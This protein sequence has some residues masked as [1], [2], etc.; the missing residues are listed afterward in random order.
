M[1]Q[2]PLYPGAT[3]CLLSHDYD[4]HN[5]Y[6]IMLLSIST[7][8]GAQ[9]KPLGSKRSTGQSTH[10]SQASHLAQTT[11]IRSEA[12]V[13]SG[14]RAIPVK[15]APPP[16]APP[17]SKAG[18]KYEL[19]QKR[20]GKNREYNPEKFLH[21]QVKKSGEGLTE[22]MRNENRYAGMIK[23]AH[24]DPNS[25]LSKARRVLPGTMEYKHKQAIRQTNKHAGAL[26]DVMHDT[27]VYHLHSGMSE[28]AFNTLNTKAHAALKQRYAIHK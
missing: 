7:S 2:A 22:A 27:R 10:P 6:F 3:L 26:A 9:I 13:S 14:Y 28:K 1:A 18:Q 25:I 15:E 19:Q 8:F 23:S 12:D 21:N 17:L 16:K 5:R 20:L 11:S 4:K 24:R